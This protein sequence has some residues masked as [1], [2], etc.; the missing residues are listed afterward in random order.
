MLMILSAE[1]WLYSNAILHYQSAQSEWSLSVQF[2]DFELIWTL[3]SRYQVE[4]EK[5]AAQ[6][7]AELESLPDIVFFK[8]LD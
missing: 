6:L 4:Y 5:R 8:T 1:V 7:R 3:L 2:V